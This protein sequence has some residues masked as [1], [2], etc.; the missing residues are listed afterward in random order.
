M[1]TMPYRKHI[2]TMRDPKFI[3]DWKKEFQFP[4]LNKVQVLLNYF[5]EEGFFVKR[6]VLCADG[7]FCA[8]QHLVPKIKYK[9][10]LKTSPHFLPTPIAFPKNVQKAINPTVCFVSRLDRRKRPEIFFELTKEF[11]SPEI[12]IYERVED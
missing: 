10:G 1:K 3:G 2:I 6:A 11:P 4:S 9:Y 12:R 8:A 7:L 5:Y